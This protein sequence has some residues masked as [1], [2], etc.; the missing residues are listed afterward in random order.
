VR[1]PDKKGHRLAVSG[2]G[3]VSTLGPTSATKSADES[4]LDS[5][6]RLQKADSPVSAWRNRDTLRRTPHGLAA[7]KFTTSGLLVNPIIGP[8]AEFLKQTPPVLTH[9]PRHATPPR[10][11]Y[12]GSHRCDPILTVTATARIKPSMDRTVALGHL[13][14]YRDLAGR[15][16]SARQGAAF[17]DLVAGGHDADHHYSGAS[18]ELLGRAFSAD[19]N[20]VLG[21]AAP[22]TFFS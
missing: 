10:F 13:A 20:R 6:H 3:V 14:R 7:P 8:S 15:G 2:P 1:R 21:V 19:N 11:S 17:D 12:E 16:V 18:T 22:R 9:S 5:N 4:D